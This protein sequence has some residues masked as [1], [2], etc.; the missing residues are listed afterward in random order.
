MLQFSLAQLEYV[1]AVDTH[2]H[3]ATAASTCHVTQPTLS[4]QIKKMEEQLGI[5]FFDRSKQPVVPTPAG[6]RVVAQAR[7]ILAEARKIPEIVQEEHNEVHGLLRI[8]IIPTLSTYLLP[9]VVGQFARDYPGIEL[10]IQE[11]LTHEV[12]ESLRKDQLDA[13]L[14]VTPLGE[15]GFQEQVLFFEEILAYFHPDQLQNLPP[16]V[17]GEVLSEMPVWLLTSGNCFREQ[18][19]NL[20][21]LRQQ[22]VEQI[23]FSF[24]SGSLETL[25]RMVDAEG[26]VTLLPE[27]MTGELGPEVRARLRPL[28]PDRA[29]RQVALVS[30]R[31]FA[32]ARLLRLFEKRVRSTIDLPANLPEKGTVVPWN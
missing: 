23:G 9:R 13:G 17:D 27:L 4:M 3:F 25:R 20:C 22:A 31:Q 16:Q 18:V 29:Y 19:L 8:G 7:R 28:G 26:G 12:L 30:R 6:K 2:R 5:V 21:A 24:E 1:V 10:H 15:P 11:G 32:K 14:V